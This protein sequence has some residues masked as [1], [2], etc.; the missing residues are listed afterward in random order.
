MR[1]MM[2]RFVILFLLVGYNCVAVPIDDFNQHFRLTP[3][4]QKIE[5][6]SG[7]GLSFSDVRAVFLSGLNK[8]P[9][10]LEIQSLPVSEKPGKG[11]ITLQLSDKKNLPS[12][13][14]GYQLVI[15][16]GEIVISARTTAGL[17][18]GCQTLSQLLEDSRDQHVSIPSCKITDF[19]ANDYRG[20]LIVLA[21]HLSVG[22]Y[23]YHIIDKLARI[24]VN[25]II[26]QF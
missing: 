5:V 2:L 18:Y 12:H 4:P 26:I 15:Y 9:A 10:V 6:L 20:V 14:E 22:N 8:I 23:Y 11:I 16:K 19:P 3:V 1:I 24:K 25:A 13:R 21:H 17:F 7:K